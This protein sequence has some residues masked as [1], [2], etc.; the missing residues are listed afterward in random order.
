M[1]QAFWHER[2][3]QNQIGFHAEAFNEHLQRHWPALQVAQ[4]EAVFVPL[5]GK[6]RDILWLTA[7]GYSVKGVELSS[8]AVKAFFAENGLSAHECRKENFTVHQLDGLRLFCGDFFQLGVNDVGDVAAVW[9]R[10]SLVAL[11]PA[12]RAAYAAIA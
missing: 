11:P 3:R 10:A 7:Q 6:S 5:C 8:V 12:M 4:G 9:D 1:D 2:W